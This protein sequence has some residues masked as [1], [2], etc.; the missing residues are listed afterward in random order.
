MEYFYMQYFNLIDRLAFC[1]AECI[2]V[3]EY[4]FYL[5]IGLAFHFCYQVSRLLYSGNLILRFHHT[6]FSALNHALIFFQTNINMSHATVHLH[7]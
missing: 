5:I 7:P 4:H 3:A 1:F 6:I 2:R